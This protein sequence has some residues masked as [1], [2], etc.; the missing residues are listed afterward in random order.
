MTDEATVVAVYRDKAQLCVG[1]DPSADI[2]ILNKSAYRALLGGERAIGEAYQRRYWVESSNLGLWEIHLKRMKG[3]LGGRPK[4]LGPDAQSIERAAGNIAVPYNIGEE[5]YRAKFDGDPYLQYSCGYYA[6][7]ATDDPT[8]QCHKLQLTGD[9]LDLR[10]GMHVLDIGGGNG[11]L[12]IFLA[13]TYGVYVDMLTLSPDQAAIAREMIRERGLERLVRVF[14]RHYLRHCGTYD[15]I[16]SVGALEHFGRSHY[17]AFFEKCNEML[18]PGGSMVIHFIWGRV[19]LDRHAGATSATH[20]WID[21]YF[22]PGGDIA[23]RSLVADAAEGLFIVL[24]VHDFGLPRAAMHPYARTNLAWD[25]NNQRNRQKIEGLSMP[26]GRI[27]DEGYFLIDH[28]ASYLFAAQ[29]QSRGITV[30]QLHFAREMPANY[31]PVR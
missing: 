9:R 12:A 13:E 24:D 22:F 6:W 3:G 29:F 26:D 15:R 31:Q 10:V 21:V 18:A 2:I 28:Y 27:Y 1:E 19:P 17:R 5:G 23:T 30:G 25:T 16:V 7:G 11:G 8:A 4:I 20:E 14:V